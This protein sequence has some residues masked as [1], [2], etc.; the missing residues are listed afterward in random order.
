[1]AMGYTGVHN[2]QRTRENFTYANVSGR[3]G[4]TSTTMLASPTAI[5][6]GTRVTLSA[7]ILNTNA[8]STRDL[9]L[10]LVPAAGADDASED[11]FF[12]VLQPKETLILPLLIVKGGQ[13]LKGFSDALNEVNFYINYKEEL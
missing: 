13:T 7:Y 2:S 3:L 1:M 8:G 4:T 5:T 12:K 6:T 9:T 11:F 10:R